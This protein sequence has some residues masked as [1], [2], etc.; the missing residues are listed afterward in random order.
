MTALFHLHPKT[1]VVHCQEPCLHQGQDGAL[2]TLYM[3][4]DFVYHRGCS[5]HNR[6]LHACHILM[7]CGQKSSN[8]PTHYTISVYCVWTKKKMG[9][10]ERIYAC[11]LAESDSIISLNFSNCYFSW[12]AYSQT[13]SNSH[14][15]NFP[16]KEKEVT[17]SKNSK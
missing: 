12:F 7:S 8:V 16:G 11:M 4:F 17:Q 9:K 6:F 2:M 10:A 1:L 5:S 13:A 3:P 14:W 15:S